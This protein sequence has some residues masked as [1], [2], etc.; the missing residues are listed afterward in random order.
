MPVKVEL[1]RFLDAQKNTY[2]HALSEIQNGK[3]TS[4]WMWFIFPQIAGLGFSETSRFYAIRDLEEAT[5]YLAHPILGKR[6]VEITSVLLA[7]QDKSAHEIFGS[8]DDM[9]LLSCMTLFSQVKNALAV[10]NDV[11]E[12]YFEGRKDVKTLELINSL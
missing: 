3:K 7:K 6:L 11:I 4:H 10:F 8:P 9:K 5:V 2:S 1:D 12:K